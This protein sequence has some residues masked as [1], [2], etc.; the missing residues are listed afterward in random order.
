MLVSVLLNEPVV[1][2][3]Q[4]GTSIALPFL[5]HGHNHGHE[6]CDDLCD[7]DHG[8]QPESRHNNEVF[9]LE[10][11]L[12]KAEKK[13]VVVIIPLRKCQLIAVQLFSHRGIFHPKFWIEKC[14]F[15]PKF[16]MRFLCFDRNFRMETA[17]DISDQTCNSYGGGGI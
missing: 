6:H 5:R 3:L 17:S 4:P 14:I 12:T 11:G 13:T 16:R 1:S 7:H 10:I 2:H 15:I 9:S 8:N